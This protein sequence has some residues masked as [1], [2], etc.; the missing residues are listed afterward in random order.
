MY[1][2]TIYGH[3]NI[4][5]RHKSTL[6]FT[7]DEDLTL[8]GDCIVGVRANYNI[9]ELRKLKGKLYVKFDKNLIVGYKNN[10]FNDDRELVIRTSDFISK[11]TFMYKS[12]L[13]SRDLNSETLRKLKSGKRINVYVDKIN[14][15]AIFFDFDNTLEDWN[16][17]DSALHEWLYSEL[18][19][20]TK[21]SIHDVIVFW[22]R[23]KEKIKQFTSTKKYSR[24]YWL[25]EFFSILGIHVSRKKIRELEDKYWKI[26]E[27]ERKLF[28]G[29]IETLKKLRRK[30]K[31]ALL[32]DSDGRREYK[33]NRLNKFSIPKY[34]DTLIIGDDISKTKPNV[35]FF[36]EASKKLGIKPY[37]AVMVGDHPEV[38]LLPAKKLGVTTVWIKKGYWSSLIKSKPRY[39]D[40]IIKDIKEVVDIAKN[41]K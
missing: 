36:I 24:Y 12:N 8:N 19:N 35:K 7:K 11:R 26:R 2:F 23:A 6:E 18:A 31:L 17:S 25:K 33:Y 41:I 1:K 38:D 15:K 39:V 13:S 28:P 3:K 30:Y 14:I 27:H 34:F 10:D 20:I 9:N 22:N 5:A 29:A 32:S 16:I 37:E 40:F 21:L 4:T